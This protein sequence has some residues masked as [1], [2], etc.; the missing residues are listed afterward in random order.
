VVLINNKDHL[1]IEG[2]H[3]IMN[4]KTSMNLGLSNIQKLEF[5][6]LY[7]VPRPIILTNNIP[8]PYWIT[9]FVN[10]EGTFDVKIYSSI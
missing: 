3:K 6:I 9:G 5:D 1:S 8:D 2:L 10:G 7:P 4:I